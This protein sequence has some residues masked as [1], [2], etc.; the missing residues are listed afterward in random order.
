VCLVRAGV[1]PFWF[2]CARGGQSRQA[3]LQAVDQENRGAGLRK[4]SVELRIHRPTIL[5]RFCL[6]GLSWAH[7][8]SLSAVVGLLVD[9]SFYFKGFSSLQ[10]L[11]GHAAD[12]R[13]ENRQGLSLPC[14]FCSRAA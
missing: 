7:G 3:S 12:P 2:K 11:V 4:P 6:A 13:G 10:R 5:D 8:S 1:V 14:R 9:E